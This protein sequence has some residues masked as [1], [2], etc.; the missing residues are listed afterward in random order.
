MLRV[1]GN[2]EGRNF[3]G[4]VSGLLWWKFLLH[5]KGMSENLSTLIYTIIQIAAALKYFVAIFLIA[6]FFFADMIDI[7]KKTSGECENVDGEMDSS[8]ET[9]CSLTPLQTYLAMYGIMVRT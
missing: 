8:L 4:I 9:F 3:V 6:I 5:V 2:V 1:N 7:V